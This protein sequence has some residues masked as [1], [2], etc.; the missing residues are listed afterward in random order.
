[1]SWLA[2]SWPAMSWCGVWSAIETTLLQRELERPQ[3]VVA[4]GLDGTEWDTQ[5]R[6]DVRLR[7]IAEVGQ[8]QHLAVLRRQRRHGLVHG[9][10]REYV[11][12]LIARRRR[13]RRFR[14]ERP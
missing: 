6:G 10:G 5:Y 11:V 14:V 13:V 3:R 4:A 7:Q 1:M 9:D 8:L 12:G 2:M